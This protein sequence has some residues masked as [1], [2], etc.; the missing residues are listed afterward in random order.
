MVRLDSRVEPCYILEAFLCPKENQRVIAEWGSVKL[1]YE[2]KGYAITWHG[3]DL[4]LCHCHFRGIHFG[5][6]GLEEK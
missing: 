3:I 1:G 4:L 2:P 5:V 6:R